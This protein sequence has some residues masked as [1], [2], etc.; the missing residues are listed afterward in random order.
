MLSMV[1]L[2]MGLD[3]IARNFIRRGISHVLLLLIIIIISM[4]IG[5]LYYFFFLFAFFFLTYMD[6]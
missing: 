1:R 4:E 2:G 3:L 6:C 5:I